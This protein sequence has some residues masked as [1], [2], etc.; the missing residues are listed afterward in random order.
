GD[1]AARVL[2]RF[3]EVGLID[4]K[5]FAAAWVDSRHTGRGLG[6]RALSAELRRRGV[7]DRTVAEAVGDL[8]PDTEL[9]TARVLV[10]RRLRSTATA[11]PA[12]RVRR[13][14]GMLARKGYPPAVAVRAVREEL[15]AAGDRDGGELAA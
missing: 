1:A 14:I 12:A 4:D 15:A 10:R 9:A 13:L 7:D 11:E 2:S 3:A 5:A 6:R 8:D